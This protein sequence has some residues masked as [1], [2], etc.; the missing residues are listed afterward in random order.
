VIDVRRE[1]RIGLGVIEGLAEQDFVHGLGGRLNVTRADEV[2]LEH[3]ADEMPEGHLPRA[4]GH[5]SAPVE[6]GRQ[7]EL[8]PVHV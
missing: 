7:Q 3:L 2:L 5:G 8:R 4:C 6:V 1:M